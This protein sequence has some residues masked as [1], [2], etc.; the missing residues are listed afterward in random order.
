MISV[1]IITKNEEHYLPILLRSL[2]EQ[3]V[4][5]G[6]I[7]VA[8][9]KSDDKTREV[10]RRF[11]CRVVEGG[12]PSLG[13]NRGAAAARSE[14][15]LFLDADVRLTD[16]HF[17]ERA[18]R[19]MAARHLDFAS[20]DIVPLSKKILDRVFHGFYNGYCRLLLPFHVHAPGFCI[21]A[22]KAKHEAMGG[23]DE[24]VIFCED[25]DYAVR[26]RRFGRF[27]YLNSVRVHVSVRRFDR[28][29]RFNVALKYFLGEF[30]L[31]FLGP[32]RHNHFKYEFGHQT[33][34]K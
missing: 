2:H 19:E 13:R 34:K 26:C 31:V 20:C 6:E 33:P 12:L 29:G 25:H 10:A 21:F 32:V 3:T 28:D 8:D 16:K 30:H 24:S 4:Q 23:F 14:I 7:I 9:A 22:R 17:L 1:V 18:E 11:G 15:V 5:P 27:G